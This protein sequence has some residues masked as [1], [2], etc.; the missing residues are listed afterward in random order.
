M[1][2]KQ[3]TDSEKLDLISKRVKSIEIRQTIQM[4]VV[5]L[6]ALGILAVI[7]EKVKKVIR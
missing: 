5:I 1:E 2:T 7:T 3:L 6:T 4:A